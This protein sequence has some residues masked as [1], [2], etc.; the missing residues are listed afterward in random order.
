MSKKIPER[1]QSIGLAGKVLRI[2]P[3][4]LVEWNFGMS[5]DRSTGQ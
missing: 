4:N 5:S 2:A 1:F 3:I